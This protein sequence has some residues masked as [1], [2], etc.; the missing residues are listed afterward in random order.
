MFKIFSRQ[1]AKAVCRPGLRLSTLRRMHSNQTPF[2]GPPSYDTIARRLSLSQAD[3]QTYFVRK[4]QQEAKDLG[5]FVDIHDISRN[6]KDYDVLI[7]DIKH[8]TLEKIISEELGIR[9]LSE[10]TESQ[11]KEV[12]KVGRGYIYGKTFRTIIPFVVSRNGE[13]RWM[14]FIMDTSAPLTYISAQVSASICRGRRRGP[15]TSLGEQNFRY[16][17]KRH[18]HCYHRRT[19]PPC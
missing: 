12:V 19:S 3:P 8:E 9:Y 17:G 7:S 18:I 4:R 6:A 10:A 13:A 1:A 16:R 11:V 2:S 14:F 5:E 15:L